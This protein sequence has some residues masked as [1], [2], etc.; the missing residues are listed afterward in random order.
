MTVPLRPQLEALATATGRQLASRL[1]SMAALAAGDGVPA[2]VGRRLTAHLEKTEAEIGYLILLRDLADA[3][4]PTGIM[5]RKTLARSILAALLRANRLRKE[6]VEYRLK[7]A[8]RLLQAGW[9]VWSVGH[10]SRML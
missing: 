3:I 7:K 2:Y 5:P 4:D 1:T 6:P 9:D 8:H 10:I